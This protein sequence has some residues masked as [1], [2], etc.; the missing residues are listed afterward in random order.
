MRRTYG[1]SRDRDTPV[2]KKDDEKMTWRNE[3]MVQIHSRLAIECSGH[4]S[5]GHKSRERSDWKISYVFHHEFRLLEHCEYPI[6]LKLVKRLKLNK[7]L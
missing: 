5:V 3:A 4:P 2:T 1:A 6:K 7:I